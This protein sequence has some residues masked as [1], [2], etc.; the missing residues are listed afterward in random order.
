MTGASV[1]FKAAFW[2]LRSADHEDRISKPCSN[3]LKPSPS[4]TSQ[5]LCSECR[6]ERR[7]RLLL[8]AERAAA[9]L[10]A[11][12]VRLRPGPARA[13][14]LRPVRVQA[15]RALPLVE[16]KVPYQGTGLI[17]TPRH[18]SLL[19]AHPGC[20]HFYQDGGQ[21]LRLGLISWDRER[22]RSTVRF[23]LK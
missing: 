22:T 15:P 16:C 8:Q 3:R 11:H 5:A 10:C 20:E 13:L 12:G 18:K 4:N 6:P 9:P 1:H 17:L 2:R 19:L 23:T 14:R 21:G 7:V